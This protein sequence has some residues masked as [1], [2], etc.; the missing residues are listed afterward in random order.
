M[1]SVLNLQ[2]LETSKAEAALG[3]SCS[4]SDFLCCLWG[5]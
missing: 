4:S 1:Q 3:D 2:K 5:D